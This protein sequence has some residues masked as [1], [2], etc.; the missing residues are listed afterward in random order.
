MLRHAIAHAPPLA[1]PDFAETAQKFRINVDA[2]TFGQGSVLW[3]P[4]F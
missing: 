4:R 1:Y 2:S 3:Q